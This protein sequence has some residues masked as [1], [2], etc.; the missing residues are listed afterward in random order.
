MGIN[1]NRVVPFGRSLADYK[2]MFTL[3]AGELQRGGNEMLVVRHTAG[4]IP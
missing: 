3:T 1:L 2:G 4:G